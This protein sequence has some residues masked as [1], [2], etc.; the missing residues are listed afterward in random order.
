MSASPWILALLYIAFLCEGHTNVSCCKGTVPLVCLP[1][2]QKRH[3]PCHEF[4]CENIT[5]LRSGLRAD[6]LCGTSEAE[7]GRE[8]LIFY[9]FTAEVVGCNRCCIELRVGAHSL[10]LIMPF[11][12]C[13]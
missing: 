6:K 5:W 1:H 7:G 9:S 11:D 12:N 4:H 8:D 2:S 10:G 3:Q 13:M